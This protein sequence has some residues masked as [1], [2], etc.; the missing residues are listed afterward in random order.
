VS[1]TANPISFSARSP[2]LFPRRKNWIPEAGGAGSKTTV[3][4]VPV[5]IP[6]PE[7]DPRFPMVFWVT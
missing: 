7:T 3:H 4:F 1:A 6:I 2:I 5:W